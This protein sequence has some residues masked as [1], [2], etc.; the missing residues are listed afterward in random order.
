LDG[1]QLYDTEAAAAEWVEHQ[2]ANCRET[3]RRETYAIARVELVDG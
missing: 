2:R 3:G 1:D